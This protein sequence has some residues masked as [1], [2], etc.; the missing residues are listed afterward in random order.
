VDDLQPDR[1]TDES[2]DAPVEPDQPV[3]PQPVEPVEPEPDVERVPRRYP[4]T[5]GG[6]FYLL[7]LA[8]SIAGLVIVGHGN[9]RLGVRWIGSA[10]IFAAVVR[11]FLPAHEA[12]MLAVRRRYLDVLLLAV[13]GVVLW[14][15]SGSIPNQPGA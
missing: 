12:G 8:A 3:E 5:I 7:V 15:L 6:A 13:V 4:S 1:R 11:L 14:F 9:W 2:G 10:L